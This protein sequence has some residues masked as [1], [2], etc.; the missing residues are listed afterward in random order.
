M[1]CFLSF[2]TLKELMLMIVLPSDCK[3][4]HPCSI[5]LSIPN[6]SDLCFHC[7]ELNGLFNQVLLLQSHFASEI[8]KSGIT[9]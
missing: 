4:S 6:F 9:K 3:T 2:D 1:I 8:R 7:M 5:Y